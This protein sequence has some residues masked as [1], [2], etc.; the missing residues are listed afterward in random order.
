MNRIIRTAVESNIER[1]HADHKLTM[2][3]SRGRIAVDCTDWME[4]FQEDA[5]VGLL[6]SEMAHRGNQSDYFDLDFCY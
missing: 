6:C 1:A 5:E 3:I 2:E 4:E